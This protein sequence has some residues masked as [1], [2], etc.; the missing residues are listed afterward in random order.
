MATPDAPN[1]GPTPT[2]P[3]VQSSGPASP[4][5]SPVAQAPRRW[6]KR[7][8]AKWCVR[9]I[10][11][12][13]ILLALITLLLMRSPLVVWTLQ[14]QVR[15][16]TGC[17]LQ[18]AGAFIDL[19]GRL[20]M[21]DFSLRA[22]G[23]PGDAATFL[24]ARRAE[25]DLDWS[26]A[27]SG[28]IR[29]DALR[30]RDPVFRVSI[31]IDSNT[32][33]IANVVSQAQAAG[34]GGGGVAGITPPRIDVIDGAIQFS[35]FDASGAVSELRTFQ[36][37]GSLTP[38]E[39]PNPIYT[40]RMQEL[41]RRGM[42]LDGRVDLRTGASTIRL[43]N[44]A[45]DTWRPETIP[46]PFRE[47]WRRLNVQG[48]VS[49]VAL[50]Y[51]VAEGP[52]LEVVL[53]NV[54]MSVPIPAE[55][56]ADR[57]EHD[58]ALR[59]V[60]GVI[61]LAQS[62]VRAEV[63]GSIENQIGRSRVRLVTS[64]LS[65]DSALTAEI[66]GR[67]FIVTRDPEFLPYI[68][69]TA[70]EYFSIFSGPTG[71]IDARVVISRGEPVNG[72]PA[73][74]RVTGGRL[75]LSRGSAAFH[76]F[77]YRFEEMNGYIEFDDKTIR[78][79]NMTGRS[80]S[81]AVLKASGI[82]SP[83]T[84]DA[85]VDITLDVTD[86]RLNQALLD[87]MPTEKRDV[88]ETIFNRPQYERLLAAGLIR[89][90]GT[91]VDP[92]V[93]NPP[94]EFAFGGVCT[95]GIVVKRPEG[96]DVE[97]T[98][99][100]DV[101]FPTAGV[102]VEPFP[103]PAYAEDLRVFVTDDDARLISGSFRAVSGGTAA[104]QAH[105]LFRENGV[106]VIK[107]DVRIDAVDI[108]IDAL[109]L[110]ALPPDVQ[111]DPS[112][113]LHAEQIHVG[114]VLRDLHLSGVVNAVALI[115]DH[116][117]SP[118]NNAAGPDD[119]GPD[120]DYDISITLDRVRAAPTPDHQPALF[121][122]EDLA[123]QMRITRERF[124]IDRLDAVLFRADHPVR[125]QAD[126]QAARLLISLDAALDAAPPPE[127]G[128]FEATI[129]A[130][131]ID[132]S[133]RIEQVISIFSPSGARS[134]ETLRAERSPA[135]RLSVQ[136]ALARAPGSSGAPG[137]SLSLDAARGVE[138][139]A[140]GGR[141]QVDWPSGVIALTIP[142]ESSAPMRTTF[143]NVRID[144]TLDD[145]PCG[146]VLLDGFFTTD[147]VSGA[148]AAPADF[149]AQLADWRF[150]SPLNG[151]LLKSVAGA[152]AA[153]KYTELDPAGAVDAV[154]AIVSDPSKGE[155]PHPARISVSFA[156]RDLAFT[157]NVERIT[158]PKVSGRVTLNAMGPGAPKSAGQTPE[159]S[160]V[161][162][163]VRAVSANWSFFAD[164][165]WYASSPETGALMID[166]DFTLEAETL[167][168][169]LR[170][171]LPDGARA[172]FDSVDA[173]FH[174]PFS[175]RD[176]R[177]RTSLGA[178]GATDFTGVLRFADLSFSAGLDIEHVTGS[179]GLSVTDPG[180]GSP[181]RFR[182]K[183]VA[184]AM[185]VLG[186]NLTNVA[187][188]LVS[189]SAP[190]EI[191]LNTLSANAH[192]GRLWGT[193]RIVTPESTAAP[194]DAASAGPP[195]PAQPSYSFELMVSG[196][197]LAPVLADFAAAGAA[198]EGP[199]GPPDPFSEPDPRRGSIDAWVSLSGVASQ[200]RTRIG[201]GSI[202][203]AD[204]DVL[205]LP[206]ILPLIQISNF[207]LPSR[208]RLGR[209]TSTFYIAGNTAFFDD[210]SVNSDSIAILGAGTLN[211]TD[212][213]LDMSFNSRATRRL[214]FLSDILEALRNELITTT[215]TGPVSD[216]RIRSESFVGTRRMIDSMFTTPAR[217][218][219]MDLTSEA[220]ARAERDRRSRDVTLPPMTIEP[221]RGS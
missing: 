195:A 118:I 62:G 17:E 204:G 117:D 20:V 90:P 55:D 171:L 43:L 169:A 32:L 146:Q 86:V 189:G 129:D 24:T 197:R 121:A 152:A 150:E 112:V 33:N 215:V 64:S 96:K 83:L 136:A 7:S 13:P 9:I 181:T 156:P 154:L 3:E 141:V 116:P 184:P 76:K 111:P 193:A 31:G 6:R 220:A 198:P 107:P 54:S 210:I 103:L 167:D 126:A 201:R 78:I 95:V 207:Q 27:L 56:S 47:V 98:T 67:R 69:A 203:I 104:V 74:V 131:S 4:S 205:S 21:R 143:D 188:E 77:P 132:L 125:T 182:A 130:R 114:N 138:F 61:R 144:L 81:G 106:K 128:R 40:I 100:V 99:N 174:G 158:L 139:A 218:A 93:P 2:A 135:G 185:R 145:R 30:L 172:A 16:L 119:D 120:V 160:G 199:V 186:V 161:L 134:L 165:E 28:D 202:R 219:D 5:P 46:T 85:M 44:L 15:A 122:L 92:A 180:D 84:D 14:S 183:A 102:V 212:L 164:G 123:G 82:I 166:V 209:V 35:E 162:E 110:H 41:G 163:E 37:A 124:R 211:L 75:S 59:D 217:F 38:T 159:V 60:N 8:I 137:V 45:L 176:G 148:V 42:I 11:G 29:V 39:I 194:A 73:E 71:E 18:A 88:V 101:H 87:A 79:V 187:A 70:R 127:R 208:D 89:E 36:V 72:K 97:W 68:P 190:G 179:I 191:L 108:P 214:P 113:P 206:V 22:P 52:R 157:Y 221:R 155:Q 153:A 173:A 23:V 51:D 109:L 105:V 170:A 200:P 213:T 26:R 58:L 66:V 178:P 49:S 149:I 94:P 57:Q 147:P 1:P 216:P 168:P 133:A 50:T 12:V 196:V 140:L 142:G 115:T 10:V 48:Q 53:D 34:G 91:K 19:D 177:V 65:L 63:T 192:A 151:P 80:E 25:L 175:L